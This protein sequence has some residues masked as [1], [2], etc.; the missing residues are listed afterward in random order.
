MP[1]LPD[2]VRRWALVAIVGVAVG[3]ACTSRS[4]GFCGGYAD[5]VSDCCSDHEYAHLRAICQQDLT[6]ASSIGAGCAR[7]VRE[8]YDC[9]EARACTHECQEESPDP[10]SQQQQAMLGI[11]SE[12]P[13]PPPVP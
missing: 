13:S 8:L 7:A 1:R 4:R 2:G 10:C 5:T 3:L 9:A 12:S 6:T 11:C